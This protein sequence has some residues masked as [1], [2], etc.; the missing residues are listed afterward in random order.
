[1]NLKFQINWPD[2]FYHDDVV[3]RHELGHALTWLLLGG[4]V[5]YVCFTRLANGLLGGKMRML[6]SE[7]GALEELWHQKPK[8]LVCRL[9]AGEIAARRYLSL[10]PQEVCSEFRLYPFSRLN[11]VLC[12]IDDNKE[13]DL[14]KAL[15][16]TN[17]AVGDKWYRWFVERHKETQS[18]VN[19]QWHTINRI[20]DNLL[21]RLPVY[22]EDVLSIS[23]SD[24]MAMLL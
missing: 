15:K 22:S 16:I 11:D 8:E 19:D 1:M 6:P 9:L 24:L 23:G 2:R 17:D 20:A 13:D 21:M 12:G 14:T 4:E 18:L 10:T 5:Q 3:V 7:G